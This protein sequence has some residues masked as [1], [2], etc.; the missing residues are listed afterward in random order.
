MGAFSS[1]PWEHVLVLMLLHAATAAVCIGLRAMQT[2]APLE[3]R[4]AGPPAV[5][6]V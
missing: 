5:A 4:L 6:S 3:R 1:M 2:R